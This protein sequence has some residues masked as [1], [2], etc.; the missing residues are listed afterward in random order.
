MAS[1]EDLQSTLEHRRLAQTAP[2]QGTPGTSLATVDD[3]RSALERSSEQRNPPTVL[4]VRRANV[5]RRLYVHLVSA[6]RAWRQVLDPSATPGS[7]AMNRAE[8]QALQ[9]TN[10]FHD[11][12]LYDRIYFARHVIKAMSE[13]DTLITDLATVYG[14]HGRRASQQDRDKLYGA[15]TNVTA[16]LP[17][18][19]E[20]LE[21]EFMGLL[22]GKP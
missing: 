5:V 19:R 12:F 20:E 21:S 17:T 7:A 1:V 22:N 3:V 16:R 2:G 14:V 10:A 13:I 9:A 11:Q 6:E 8:E 15:W 18:I 4:L